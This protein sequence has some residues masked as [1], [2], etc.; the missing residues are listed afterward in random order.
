MKN[1]ANS[2]FHLV[3]LIKLNKFD[4]TKVTLVEKILEENQENYK[5]IYDLSLTL[6]SASRFNEALLLLRELK[7]SNNEDNYVT[8]NLGLLLALLKD[9]EYAIIYFD[10]IISKNNRDFGALINKCASLIDLEKFDDAN[11]LIDSIISLNDQIPEAW[12]NKAIILSKLSKYSLAIDAY[13]HALA[14]NVNN[15]EAYLNLS[16]AYSK[17]YQLNE[18][19]ES[20]DKALSLKPDY[21]EAWSNRS[22]TLNE[23]N[24]HQEALESC[25]KALSLKP[26]YAEAW[27]NRSYTLNELN[28][29]QEALESC[30]KALSLKPDYAE[31]WYN[32]GVSLYEIASYDEADKSFDNAILFKENYAEAWYNKGAIKTKERKYYEAIEFYNNALKINT[33]YLE[34]IFNQGMC[35][36]EIGEYKKAIASYQEVI[37][38]NPRFAEAWNNSGVILSSLKLY[39]RALQSFKLAYE[40]K[41]NI[42]WLLGQLIHTKMIMCSWKGLA[43]DIDLLSNN[44]SKNKKVIA[45]FPAL[46]VFDSPELLQRVARL[47]IKEKFPEKGGSEFEKN[48]KKNE[49]IKIG[50]FSGDFGDHPISYLMTE[51]FELHNRNHFEI[52]GFSFRNHKDSP[53][54]KRIKGA[55][56]HYYDLSYENDREVA[57]LSRNLGIDIAVDLMGHTKDSRTGIFSNRAAPIQL[58]YLGYLGTIGAN[59][60]DYLIADK[61][62]ITADLKGF[63]DEKIISLPSYQANDRKK[64]IADI[65]FSKSDLGLPRECFVFCCFNNTYKILPTIFDG[66]MRVLKAVDNS[67]L[68]LFAENPWAAEN[69]KREAKLRGVDEGRII[70]ATSIPYHEYLARYKICDLFLDTFPYNAGTTASDALW[71]GVPI[72]TLRGQSFSSRM[73]SSLL[74]AVGLSELIAYDQNEYETLAIDLASNSRKLA[75]I[76]EK[77]ALNRNTEMLFDSVKFTKNYESALSIIHQRRLDGLRP[78]HIEII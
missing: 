62:I 25:D 42:D 2:F 32:R 9:H 76:K 77:L 65:K 20:C 37:N 19:L 18:A 15:Y 24:R 61:V 53:F 50:Y 22:Y 73:A 78:D 66:W 67:V 14:L 36:G 44:I 31:A 40:I 55:F 47:Y 49:K 64:L 43:E 3:D 17:N 74:T 29:H 39:D 52:Y 33:S 10:E 13:K 70:F 46:V 35:F 75:K 6:I 21:A 5:N 12:I 58:S 4:L 45:P 28:R 57:E 16:V 48:K 59:Y 51:V 26:D 54:F 69:L 41:P 11:S 71:M 1:D 72:L 60:I 23:L 8:Y 68:Y 7:K 56:D 27:S 34:A 30:D 63:Y 38:A